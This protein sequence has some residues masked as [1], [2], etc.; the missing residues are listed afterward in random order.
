[1][2]DEMKYVE[3]D[4]MKYVELEYLGGSSRFQKRY[5]VFRKSDVPNTIIIEREQYGVNTFQWIEKGTPTLSMAAIGF[6]I[7]FILGLSLGGNPVIGLAG[8]LMGAAL[9]NLRKDTS[10]IIFSLQDNENKLLLYTR[11]SKENFRELS[12]IL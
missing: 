1:M 12:E 7:G 3:I 10:I 4:E 5:L 6:L 9:L 8:G 2:I 11:C